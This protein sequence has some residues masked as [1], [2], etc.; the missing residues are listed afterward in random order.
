MKTNPEPTPHGAAHGARQWNVLSLGAGVQS[1][2]LRTGS[3][4]IVIP[5]NCSGW[6]WHCLARETGRVGHLYSPGGQRGPWPWLP[7]RLDNGAFACWNMKTNEFDVEKW[8][9]VEPDWRR[10][11][12][13]SATAT[14]NAL[15]GIVPDTPGNAED[16]FRKWARYSQTVVD[17]EI[18]LA[19][20]VQDG[21]EPADVAKLRPAPSVVC[22]GGSTDWKWKT[23]ATWADHFRRVHVLRVNELAK[24]ELLESLGVESCDGTGWGRGRRE[25]VDGLESFLRRNVSPRIYSMANY[26]CRTPRKNGQTEWAFR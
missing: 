25:R 2:T 19:I 12:Y 17:A 21:M 3:P 18:P 24:L 22:V 8:Q 15:W 16:T 23:V 6:F 1:S 11:L 26:T 14:Q 10:L 5:A 13:W 20:A 9:R 7:Y 4:L